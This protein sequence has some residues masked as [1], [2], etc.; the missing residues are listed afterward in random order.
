MQ[1][2]AHRSTDLAP[3][4]AAWRRSS[5]LVAELSVVTTNFMNYRVGLAQAR[6]SLRGSPD[7]RPRPLW[8]ELSSLGVEMGSARASRL[9]GSGGYR[10]SDAIR[11][12]APVAF[13]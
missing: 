5:S 6:A 1:A 9:I 10:G 8:T 4:H 7:T 11:K 3:S 2:C 13:T 12:P